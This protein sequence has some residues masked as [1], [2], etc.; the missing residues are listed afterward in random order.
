MGQSLAVKYRPKTFEEVCGQS[1]VVKILEKA[2]EQKNFKHAYLFAGDSG[3]GKTTLA[4]CFAN[5]INQN[6]GAPIEL[7]AASQRDIETIRAIR[8][9]ASER[10][11]DSE[12]KIFIIDECQSYTIVQWQAFLKVIEETPEY[13]IFMF[14]TTEPN[15]LPQTILNRLQRYNITKISPQVIKARLIEICQKEGF[16]NYEQACEI[17]SKTSK[18]CM[19]DAIMK[20]EQC[21]SYSTDLKTENVSQVLDSTLFATLFNLTWAL[22]DKNEEGI[23]K[24]IDQLYTTGVDLRNFIDNY[25][26]FALDLAKYIIS[27]DIEITNIPAYLA[28]DDN[29][30]VQTTI[31][32]SDALNWF[33]NLV[34]LLLTIKLD[35]KYDNSCKSTITAYL[36]RACR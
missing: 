1:I 8:S 15:K 35:I 11:L 2:I 6:A 7:D 22:Q 24:N 13:A 29:P 20:L 26:D 3:C 12:Y 16:T 36:L 25:L 27:K 33:R 14:C 4:R 32:I 18:G 9:S 21:A 23:I 10:S 19:R 5:A 34:D 30:V 28:A 31:N 17:I